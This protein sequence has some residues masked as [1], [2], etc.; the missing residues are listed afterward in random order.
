[1]SQVKI[2]LVGFATM[3]IPCYVRESP[4]SLETMKRYLIDAFPLL[5]KPEGVL[6]G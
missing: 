5:A 4:I 3:D 6:T 2:E 1:M